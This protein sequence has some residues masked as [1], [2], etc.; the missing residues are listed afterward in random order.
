[1]FCKV[2]SGALKG[3]EGHIIQVE[4]DVS[5][6]LPTFDMV[7]LLSS[8]VK[9]SRER[10]RTSLKNSGLKFLLNVLRLIFLQQT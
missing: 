4:S 2:L 1:M 10:V 6:G 3:I 5:D 8:E 7:G 9:E